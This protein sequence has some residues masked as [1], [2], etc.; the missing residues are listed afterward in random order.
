MT[1]KQKYDVELI[2]WHD[3]V[4]D[5]GWK[6]HADAEG[7]QEVHSIGL[8]VADND[9]AIV[10]GGSWGEGGEGM[11]TNNRITIPK[12]WVIARKKVRV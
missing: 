8:V 10:L 1:K 9:N 7:T 2:I 3:A 11:E 12:S 5:V 6:T 4:A